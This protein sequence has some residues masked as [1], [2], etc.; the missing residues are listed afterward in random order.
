MLKFE[1]VDVVDWFAR[2]KVFRVDLMKNNIE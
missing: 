1:L 2:E